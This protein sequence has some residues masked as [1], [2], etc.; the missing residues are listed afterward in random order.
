MTRYLDLI[1]W[2]E[3]DESPG[4]YRAV[5]NTGFNPLTGSIHVSYTR[6]LPDGVRLGFQVLQPQIAFMSSRN[7][8]RSLAAHMIRQVRIETRK[9]AKRY[10]ST[11]G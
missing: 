8:W 6:T 2:A 9:A 5:L 11:T 4:G 1:A 10:S 3:S 7:G